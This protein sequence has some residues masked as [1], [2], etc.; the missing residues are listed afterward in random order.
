MA[1]WPFEP[2]EELHIRLHTKPTNILEQITLEEMLTRHDL[3]APPS[4]QAEYMDIKQRMEK[5]RLREKWLR[6]MLPSHIVRRITPDFARSATIHPDTAWTLFVLAQALQ[7]Q[8]V[9]ETGTYWGYSTSFLAAALANNPTGV[10][11]TIDLSKESG[12]RVPRDLRSRVKFL[13]RQSGIS[14]LR[15]LMAQVQP[16]LF[17]QDSVHDYEGVRAELHEVAS[18]MAVGSVIAVHDAAEPEVQ[19]ALKTLNDFALYSLVSDDPQGLG[20]AIKREIVNC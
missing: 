12:R 19:N 1:C 17:F 16:V 3:Q 15:T 20:V 7:A 8:V 14:A 11:Y 4:A 5:V 9:F 2:Q 18:G 6:S 13:R 10:V